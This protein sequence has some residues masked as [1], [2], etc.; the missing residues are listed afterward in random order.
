MRI[1]MT[2]KKT[3]LRDN[4]GF[5]LLEVL[6]VVAIISILAAISIPAYQKVKNNAE[7]KVLEYNTKM[8]SFVLQEYL[9]EQ[10]MEGNS[11]RHTVRQLTSAPV[12]DPENPLSGRIEGTDLDDTWIVYVNANYG[13]EGYGGFEIEWKNYRVKCYAGKELEIERTDNRSGKSA[14]AGG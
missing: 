10:R 14:H 1:P 7:V 9:E 2:G 3:S 6:T 12:G 13:T 4:R 8:I 5:T 11:N